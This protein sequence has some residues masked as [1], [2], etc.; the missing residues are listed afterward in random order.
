[1]LSVKIELPPFS[2]RYHLKVHSVQITSLQSFESLKP[3]P[4]TLSATTN[5]PPISRPLT[6]L[7][8]HFLVHLHDYMADRAS[9]INFARRDKTTLGHWGQADAY[10]KI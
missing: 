1:M 6:K 5:V 10:L 9:K 8:F 7:A 4:H 2:V 3:P